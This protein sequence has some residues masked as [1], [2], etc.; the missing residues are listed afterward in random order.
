MSILIFPISSKVQF[1]MFEFNYKK[2]LFYFST[3]LVLTKYKNTKNNEEQNK[4]NCASKIDKF[5]IFL[6]SFFRR[7]PYYE[8]NY[9]FHLY[10]KHLF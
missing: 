1:K 5:G 10:N 3:A 6:Y 2:V 9:V 7:L 8:I 4:S